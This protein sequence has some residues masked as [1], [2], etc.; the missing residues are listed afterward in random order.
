MKFI[1]AIDLKNNKV[2]LA[3]S[4]KRSDYKE[5]PKSLAPSSDPLDF[6]EYLL[7]KYH[8]N[9]IYLADLD[10]IDNFYKYSSSIEK[11]LNNFNNIHFLLD[12]GIQKYSELSQYNSKNYTQIIATESFLEY[13][14]LNNSSIE[15]ILSLDFSDNKVI[16]LDSDYTTLKPKKIICMSLDNIGKQCGPNYNDISIS[17]KQY[18]GV[19]VI[20][21]GGIKNNNDI[22]SLKKHGLKEVI[23]LTSILEN[24]INF[25]LAY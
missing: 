3:T 1:P 18:P 13:G 10:S 17:Q 19:E 23:L 15:Y 4:S 6:I 16:A 25:N 24:K 20:V 7:S 9:T 14:N 2:V 5:I 12:N 21:S 8:F 11:I 22:V